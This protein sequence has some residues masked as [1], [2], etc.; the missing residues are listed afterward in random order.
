MRTTNTS[1]SW[2][3]SK[4][5]PAD[6]TACRRASWAIHP[7]RASTSDNLKRFLR[8]AKID[9]FSEKKVYVQIG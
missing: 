6:P 7:G 8:T 3:T 5:G 1:V 2:P 9:G 4:G